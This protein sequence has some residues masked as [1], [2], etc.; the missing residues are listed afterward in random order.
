MKAISDIKGMEKFKGYYVNE[1]GEIYTNKSKGGS[2][3]KNGELRILSKT[4]NS[5]GYVSIRLNDGEKLKTF[6]LHRIVA[7][8]FI[9]NPENKRTVDHINR[10]KEDNR[11]E[12]LRWA[13]MREQN[14]NKSHNIWNRKKVI[15][16][17]T[18]EVFDSADIASKSLGLK[19]NQ[20]ARAC[21][22]YYDKKHNIITEHHLK[23]G[24][25][26]KAKGFRWAYLEDVKQLT[27]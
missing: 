19:S 9:P 14:N 3:L 7:L 22:G 21:K 16:L 27:I 17:D 4:V 26:T 25:H 12:N 6:L 20:V 24:Y 8:A 23:R 15:N 10:D 1:I 18:K 13:T 2:I 11:V 5:K